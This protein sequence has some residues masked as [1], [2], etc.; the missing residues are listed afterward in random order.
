MQLCTA[1]KTASELLHFV[2]RWHFLLV[3]HLAASHYLKERNGTVG[4]KGG[5]CRLA[6]LDPW[7]FNGNCMVQRPVK[8]WITADKQSQAV[9][10]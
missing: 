4:G 9:L 7:K 5:A 2:F 6:R 10:T 8:R 1:E 3:Y